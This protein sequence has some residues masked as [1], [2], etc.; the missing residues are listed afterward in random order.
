LATIVFWMIAVISGLYFQIGPWTIALV[1]V[2]G[3][4]L[5]QASYLV[6]GVL[7]SDLKSSDLHA[8]T[9]MKHPTSQLM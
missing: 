5:L 6:V 3:S 7:S 2:A 9:A 1:L 4:A 8:P